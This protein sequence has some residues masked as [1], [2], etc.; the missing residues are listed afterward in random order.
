MIY[1]NKAKYAE[2]ARQVRALP[3]EKTGSTY[4]WEEVVHKMCASDD[5]GL[6]DRGINE[7]S[8]LKSSR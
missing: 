3:L 5:A 6:H 2:I 8:K 4:Q 7:L 1:I